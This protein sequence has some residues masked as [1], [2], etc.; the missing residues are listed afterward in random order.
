MLKKFCSLK[1]IVLLLW[2]IILF[3]Q[4]E[5]AGSDVAIIID[6]SGCMRATDEKVLSL[7]LTHYILDQIDFL[8]NDPRVVL[9]PFSTEVFSIPKGHLTNDITQLYEEV[10][11]FPKPFG[12]TDI[13]AA[14]L[15]ARQLL[16]PFDSQ[17]EKLIF[18]ITDGNP[19]P[20]P[21]DRNRFPEVEEQF[22]KVSDGVNRNSTNYE[23]LL[24]TFGKKLVN[25]TRSNILNTIAP[26]FR[27]K[28]ALFTIALGTQGID[29]EFLIDLSLRV[30]GRPDNFL[31]VDNNK[32]FIDAANR[33]FPKGPN[34]IDFFSEKIQNTLQTKYEK[35]F[36][37]PLSLQR[38][39][40]TIN[41]LREGVEEKDIDILLQPPSVGELNK[42]NPDINYLVAKDHEGKGSI[43]FQRYLFENPVPHGEWKILIKRSGVSIQ[44][45]H[46]LYLLGEGVA[47]AKLDLAIVP[48]EPVVGDLVQMIC[49]IVD[50][51]SNIIPI[52]KIDGKIISPSGNI[53]NLIFL[54]LQDGKMRGEFEIIEKG[55]H[56]VETIAYVNE[57]PKQFLK[58]AKEFE[59]KLPEPI[60]IITQIPFNTE[61]GS[62]KKDILAF[63]PIGVDSLRSKI[64]DGIKIESLSE[65]DANIS[66]T[67]MPLENQKGHL[68][69]AEEWLIISTENEVTINQNKPH[70]FSL[71]ATIP[72]YVGDNIE[73]GVYKGELIVDSKQI[74]EPLKIPIELNIIIP[75]LEV[76]EMIVFNRFWDYPGVKNK[77]I[78]VRTNAAFNLKVNVVPTEYLEEEEGQI[79]DNKIIN[80]E[81]NE[82]EIIVNRDNDIEI[83]LSANIRTKNPPQNRYDGK[84]YFYADAVRDTLMYT[85]VSISGKPL[86]NKYRVYALLFGLIA[87][88]I[89]IPFRNRWRQIDGYLEG[90]TI[91]LTQE[92]IKQENVYQFR[93]LFSINYSENG[94]R[95]TG[96]SNILINDGMIPPSGQSLQPSDRIT[97]EEFQFMVVTADEQILSLS[98]TQS[99]Y[100]R[101]SN[102]LNI[103]LGLIGTILVLL[104]LLWFVS[105]KPIPPFV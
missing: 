54:S 2:T 21:G 20:N 99:P 31:V 70:S 68:L 86:R 6:R 8:K 69:S 73:N 27:G 12:N 94:F 40:L 13:E 63:P 34:I 33:L 81:T 61:N 71:T 100:N 39:R 35:S 82:K 15:L 64:I 79:I 55:K 28:V 3:G 17:R 16:A 92:Q 103:S 56:I 83:L 95:L 48:M 22:K 4:E 102:R 59:A 50:P 97:G 47:T 10:N 1:I 41:Y 43:V 52:K 9:I 19:I 58:I 75:T 96:A 66:I 46:D 72:K 38:F 85:S 77:K 53:T 87:L 23:N 105:S 30:N 57:S 74:S 44:P 24:D 65:R 91:L 93:D 76:P 98:I 67:T 37:L 26:S 104:G 88:L 32:E 49:A 84:V 11:R 45:I 80:I 78:T 29:E 60:M 7:A 25:K 42:N 89:S 51:V 18:M 36:N 90:D 62:I 101:I 14:L 5:P